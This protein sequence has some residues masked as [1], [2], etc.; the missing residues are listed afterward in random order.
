M[1][2]LVSKFDA[3]GVANPAGACGLMGGGEGQHEAA[4]VACAGGRCR[5]RVVASMR[6]RFVRSKPGRQRREGQHDGL[7]LAVW[8][9]ENGVTVGTLFESPIMHSVDANA[10]YGDSGFRF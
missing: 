1:A 3:H 5:T 8:L 2:K 6:Q 7:V 4:V 9:G 10:D